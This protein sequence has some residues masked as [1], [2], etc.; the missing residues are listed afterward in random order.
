MYELSTNSPAERKALTDCINK[1]VEF[2]RFSGQP[3]ITHP[4]TNPFLT[5]YQEQ[6]QQQQQQQQQQQ[7]QANSLAN[8]SAAGASGSL[9]SDPAHS[10]RNRPLPSLPT[11]VSLRAV[12]TIAT[13]TDS[14]QR[15]SSSHPASLMGRSRS[16]D[17]GDRNITLP[18]PNIFSASGTVAT[19]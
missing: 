10:I 13:S 14:A 4:S 17:P 7:K 8:A 1:L 5:N 16:Q 12:A 15:H 3:S 19:A 11:S 2:K 9:V 6:V 18:E